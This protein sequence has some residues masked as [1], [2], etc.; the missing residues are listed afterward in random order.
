LS[1]QWF[2]W[3]FSSAVGVFFLDVVLDGRTLW[4]GYA[5]HPVQKFFLPPTSTAI[6]EDIWQFGQPVLVAAVTSV[7]FFVLLAF[8]KRRWKLEQYSESDLGLLT[9]VV[10]VSGWPGFFLSLVAIF[11][12]S[13]LYSLARGIRHPAS[14]K[15]ARLDI[16]PQILPTVGVLI[17]FLPELLHATSL[18]KIRF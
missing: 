8:V 9:L 1:P 5:A 18:D 6:F 16:T 7:L 10:F 15:D 14:L 13:V 2:A 4:E 11:V 12:V 17:W 3:A